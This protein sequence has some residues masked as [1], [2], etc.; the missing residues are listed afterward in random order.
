MA[1]K[2]IPRVEQIRTHLEAAV[3]AHEK[4]LKLF[5]SGDY[6]RIPP[7]KEK[8]I[9]DCCAECAS[10][11]KVL[12]EELDRDWANVYQTFADGGTETDCRIGKNRWCFG[13][14]EFARARLRSLG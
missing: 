12:R 4:G 10:H 3:S 7:A 14:I 8:E 6:S 2:P 1:P 11:F 9:M 13:L 5:G